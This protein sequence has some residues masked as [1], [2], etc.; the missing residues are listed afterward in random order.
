[1]V[2]KLVVIYDNC[3]QDIPILITARKNEGCMSVLNEFNG[4]QAVRVHHLLTGQADLMQKH[5]YW[6]TL[7]DCANAGTYCSVCNKKAYKEHYAN[8]KEK[9]RFCPNCG[10][11]MDGK[12]RIL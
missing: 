11:I 4:E 3:S 1:M 10:G 7:T 6:Y 9:S 5:G 12:F 8:V 2:D